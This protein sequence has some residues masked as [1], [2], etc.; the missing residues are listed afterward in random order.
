MDMESQNVDKFVKA[1][2]RV[3]A[4]KAFYSEVLLF[5]L[6][7]FLL[8]FFRENVIGLFGNVGQNVNFLKWLN[9]NIMLIPLWWGI[10]LLVKAKCVFNYKFDF[11][12]KW[13]QKK[14]K[15]YME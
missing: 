14:I 6:I 11:I 13:E 7:T 1:H 2:K 4:I 5:L 8:I 9:L 12:E 15:K 10:I 3:K